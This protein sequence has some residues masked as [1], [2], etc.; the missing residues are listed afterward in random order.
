M[1]K[2]KTGKRAVTHIG[3]DKKHKQ[4]KKQLKSKTIDYCDAQQVY[5]AAKEGDLKKL[6]ILREAKVFFPSHVFVC[7]AEGGHV[8]VIKQLLE[9]GYK[10]HPD[11]QMCE[12]AAVN[13]HLECLKFVRG[14][15]FKWGLAM[16]WASYKSFHEFHQKDACSACVEYMVEQGVK[17]M[18]PED[19]KSS[20]EEEK[21]EVIPE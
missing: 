17:R 19:F 5:N 8:H 12:H 20:K 3:R 6:A 9:W 11:S 4:T 21:E 13:G 15:G 2:S 16:R 1:A 18:T 7:A 14:M 10:L